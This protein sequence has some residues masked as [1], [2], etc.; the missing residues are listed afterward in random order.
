MQQ[1]SLDGK[2]FANE[3]RKRGRAVPRTKNAIPRLDGYLSPPL[4]ARSREAMTRVLEAF[5]ALLREKSY[6]RIRID[7]I[8]AK[9][10]TATSS[11]YARFK[12]KRAILMVLH[13]DVAERALVHH[14]NLCNPERHKSKS[15]SAMMSDIVIGFRHWYIANRNFIHAILTT[16]DEGAYNRG[17]FV[18]RETAEHY[19]QSFAVLFPHADRQELRRVAKLIV[20]TLSATLQQMTVYGDLHRER[21]VIDDLRELLTRRL[22]MAVGAA[23]KVKRKRDL[24]NIQP[25]PPHTA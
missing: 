19:S 17:K 5:S 14:K 1:V 8:A 21:V 20:R 25:E 2:A 10:E 22:E 15:A 7:E 16:D 3:F 24:N 6:D 4:Q 11:I 13:L 12:D 9:A 23:P 18:F